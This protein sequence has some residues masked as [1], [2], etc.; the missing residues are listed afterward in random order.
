MKDWHAILIIVFAGL[1]AYISSLN[2]QFVFDD[3]P[4]IVK[5][6]FYSEKHSFWECWARSFWQI[7]YPQ[8]LY[9]PV[10][11]FSYWINAR[12]GGISSFHFKIFNLLFHLA[13]CVLLFIYLKK[14]FGKAPIP[15][16]AAVIF[17]VHPIHIEAVVPAFGRGELLCCFFLLLGLILH[18]L[19]K[20]KMF[21]YLLASVAFLFALWSKEHA[22]IFLP[23]CLLQD[24][25]L[26]GT[27]TADINN[28]KR[29]MSLKYKSYLLCLSVIFVYF[30]S[31]YLALQTFLFPPFTTDLA[32]DNPL[33]NH[34][35]AL[36][37]VS[38][39]EIQS[40]AIKLL[41]WPSVLS[42]DYSFAQLLPASSF[43]SAKAILFCAIF[44]SFIIIAGF[45]FNDIGKQLLFFALAYLLSV[46][47]AGNF[48]FASGTIFAER[49]LYIPSIWIIAFA[50]GLFLRISQR[51][52]DGLR[53]SLV[54]LITMLLAWRTIERS[55]DWESDMSLAIA[56]VKTSPSSAKMWNNLAFQLGEA[57]DYAAALI[58]A[59]KA[60]SIYPR[61]LTALI[62]RGVYYSKLG[63]FSEAERDFRQAL[64]LSPNNKHA[65]TNL[66]ILLKNKPITENDQIKNEPLK[67]D[68]E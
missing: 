16:S 10:T 26:R 28:S 60:I 47:P 15:F 33:A 48:I 46:L 29:N 20:E 53:I 31:R 6:Q 66:E 22:I 13:N 7:G 21:F 38:A 11:T 52:S 39:L 42:H 27:Y 41:F 59:N 43:F 50:A 58:A 67:T 3:I 17:A 24:I 55:Y 32:L 63:Y 62:N 68:T 4:L 51:L 64:S 57:G 1:L 37:F 54:C 34:P 35:P 40:F 19:A 12:L 18:I 61:Y 9:R 30:V 56:G 65:L 14:L 23:L 44:A 45:L 8:T 25:L 36:R 2:G 5:D 49:L